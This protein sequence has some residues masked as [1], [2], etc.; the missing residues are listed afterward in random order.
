MAEK[1]KYERPV[2][3]K[4]YS[5]MMNKFGSGSS[6]A[7]R[8][9]ID[10]VPVKKL[11]K[12]FGSPLFVLSE[13]AI[14][15][16]QRTAYRIFKNRYP[17]VQFAWSYKTN[18]LNAVCALFHD[19]GSWAEVVSAFEYEKARDLGIRGGPCGPDK[20]NPSRPAAAVPPKPRP[21]PPFAG[22]WP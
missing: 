8:E 12:D 4:H 5:G 14:R 2:V 19:E 20:G 10:D 1:K 17:K 9:T 15:N 22:N 21:R 11:L 6:T 18:Y 13:K 16:N 3:T 7:V